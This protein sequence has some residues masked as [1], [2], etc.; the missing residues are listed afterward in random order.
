LE[1]PRLDFI[2]GG[3]PIIIRKT[4]TAN[5]NARTLLRQDTPLVRGNVYRID[6]LFPDGCA[7]L[8]KVAIY[9]NE[10]RL[11]PINPGEW[12][13][14]NDELLSWRTDID[15][16][17]NEEWSLRGYNLDD[18]YDHTVT[19]RIF[20]RRQDPKPLSL[21]LEQNTAAILDMSETLKR[22]VDLWGTVEEPAEVEESPQKVLAE[23]GKTEGS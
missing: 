4:F 22:F 7:Q 13:D 6:L 10:G 17:Q 18:T 9:R 8:A 20:I 14:G 12:L 2:E 16:N 1:S 3:G 5:G 19:A 21:L 11:F 15:T 23:A